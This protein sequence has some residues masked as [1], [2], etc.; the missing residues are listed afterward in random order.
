MLVYGSGEH[1]LYTLYTYVHAYTE[2]LDRGDLSISIIDYAVAEV[3]EVRKLPREAFLLPQRP[4]DDL[5]QQHPQTNLATT[6][7]PPSTRLVGRT[8]GGLGLWKTRG[9]ANLYSSRVPPGH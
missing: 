1:P 4:R 7:W 8:S 2:H 5:K 3:A 6:A 9:A